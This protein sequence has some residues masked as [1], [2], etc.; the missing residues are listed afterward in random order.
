MR[1]H[2]PPDSSDVFILL[3]PL[4]TVPR[5]YASLLVSPV[6]A[7]GPRADVSLASSALTSAHFASSALHHRAAMP[8][9]LS[10]TLQEQRSSTA[11]QRIAVF[12]RSPGVGERE[13]ERGSPRREPEL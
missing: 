9:S 8:R 2:Q 4:P 1:L 13:E 11:A 3:A 12:L 6:S 10:L 7:R 5:A